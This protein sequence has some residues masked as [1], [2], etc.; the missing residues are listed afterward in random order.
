MFEDKE[1]ESQSASQSWNEVKELEQDLRN[2]M[3]KIKQISE[4][5]KFSCHDENIY[6][7]SA[8]GVSF[9]DIQQLIFPSFH[10]QTNYSD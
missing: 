9:F 1:R 10:S 5:I 2:K 7:T 3:K 8:T 6:N 4:S